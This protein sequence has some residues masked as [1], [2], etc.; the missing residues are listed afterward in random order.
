[1][2]A[3][4]KTV[5]PSTPQ[6]NVPPFDREAA[7]SILEASLGQPVDQVFAQFEMEPIAAASLGQVRG[8]GVSEYERGRGR[9]VEGR[10]EVGRGKGQ[11]ADVFQL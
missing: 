1:M 10:G 11:A 9:R 4:F 8:E 3:T 2:A 6:D 5:P 7:R